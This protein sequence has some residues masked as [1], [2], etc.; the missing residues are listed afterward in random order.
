MNKTN[1]F[2]TL[3]GK[4]VVNLSRVCLVNIDNSIDELTDTFVFTLST[5][6]TFQALVDQENILLKE[7]TQN[8][9]Y[10][11]SFP[12][13]DGESLRISNIAEDIKTPFTIN[14]ITEIWAGSSQLLLVAVK[15]FNSERKNIFSILTETDDIDLLEE[16][17]ITSIVEQMVFGYRQVVHLWHD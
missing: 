12:L 15:F 17:N 14:G 16:D 13:E 5:G 11:A 8:E 9:G 10:I 6:Q 7:I 4:K 3:I 1:I 2:G